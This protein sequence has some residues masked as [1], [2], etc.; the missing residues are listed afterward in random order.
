MAASRRS[1]TLFSPKRTFDLCLFS[2]SA[3]IVIEAKAHQEFDANQLLSFDKDKS[4]IRKEVAVDR[5]LLTGIAS[6]KY[7]PPK[8]V[9][10]HFNGSFLTWHE[11]ASHFNNDQILLRANAIYEPNNSTSGKSN[12]GGYM[13]GS[14]LANAYSRDEEFLVGRNSGLTGKAIM[15]DV[16]S[17][18]FRTHKYETNR[19]AT[20]INSN[21]FWLSE[22]MQLISNQ[23]P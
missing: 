23:T 4:Q 14:E 11:L 20:E 15:A 13:T 12:T 2:D 8:A 21:W 16:C 6:S 1:G 7:R 9:L 22:F 5:V 10:D 3:I 17:G 18:S 19:E